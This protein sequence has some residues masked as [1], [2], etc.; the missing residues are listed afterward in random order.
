[1]MGYSVAV[2]GVFFGVLVLASIGSVPLWVKVVV[3]AVALAWWVRATIR[4]I[5]RL[6]GFV[7]RRA[8][9]GG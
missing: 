4:E 1:M 7:R 2:I 5:R 3:G 6:R 8:G 9:G